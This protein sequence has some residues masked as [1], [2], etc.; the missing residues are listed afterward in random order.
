MQAN[1]ISSRDHA[2]SSKCADCCVS[3]ACRICLAEGAAAAETAEEEEG[4]E[5]E[6]EKEEARVKPAVPG[7]QCFF[8]AWQLLLD[9]PESGRS[10]AQQAPSLLPTWSPECYEPAAADADHTVKA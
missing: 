1:T 4:G 10:S 2:A 6:K 8:A 3:A 7:L 5:R 9:H